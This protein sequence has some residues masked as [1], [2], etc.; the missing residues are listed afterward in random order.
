MASS[1]IRRINTP[2]VVLA[3]IM[4]LMALMALMATRAGGLAATAQT[5]GAP[6]RFSA[7]AVNMENGGTSSVQIV[8]NR[9][10]TDRERDRL[11]SVLME[12]GA[13]KLLDVLRDTPKVGYIRN[14]SSIGWDLHYARRVAL[15]DGGEQVTLATDRP[16]G[17]WEASHQP[18]TIDYPFTVVEL[19]LNAEGEG[20]GKMSY[21]TKIIPDK[22]NKVIV[23]E[24]YGTQPVLLQ[25]VKRERAS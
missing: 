14:V 3:G 25:G 11:L 12:K 9:W 6:E 7:L 17:F 8:V 15:P 5:S 22:E 21:A 1:L 4:A 24:N 19:R 10:S 2:A 23:L 13:D 16:I 20:E 18:R